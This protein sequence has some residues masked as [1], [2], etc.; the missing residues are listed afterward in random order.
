[1]FAVR[2]GQPRPP[3]SIDP[4]LRWH[5]H[6]RVGSIGRCPPR[7]LRTDGA[8]S[9]CLLVPSTAGLEPLEWADESAVAGREEA[10]HLV[11]KFLGRNSQM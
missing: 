3:E 8:L 11:V 2:A 4:V 6:T 5:R 7:S 9:D 10:L 1:M